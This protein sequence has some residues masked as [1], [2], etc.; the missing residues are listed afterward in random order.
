MHDARKLFVSPRS[1]SARIAAAL[2]PEAG[3]A[4]DAQFRRK[5]DLHVKPETGAD[6]DRERI[7]RAAIARDL[8]VL[9]GVDTASISR[10]PT[11][12]WKGEATAPL[13][14]ADLPAPVL[15]KLARS[16][17]VPT[18]PRWEVA[19]PGRWLLAAAAAGAAA[20]VSITLPGTS[21]AGVALCVALAVV[22][23]AIAAIGF[24][25]RQRRAHVIQGVRLTR[26]E[27]DLV[28]AARA[29]R[30]LRWN[31]LAEEGLT[32]LGT[33][34]MLYAHDLLEA[35]GRHQVW[36]D[37]LFVAAMG[38]AP[39]LDTDEEL[40]QIACSC[41]LLDRHTRQPLAVDASAAIEHDELEGRLR[42]RVLALRLYLDELDTAARVLQAHRADNPAADEQ[43]SEVFQAAAEN[44]FASATIEQMRHRISASAL[45]I[46]DIPTR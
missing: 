26:A 44:E 14:T 11:W 1:S 28:A 3:C 37:P 36:R 43:Q 40:F 31:P 9:A 13:R 30:T 34:I 21:R 42:E 2:T 29:R 23:F 10:G 20:A 12:A 27:R 15:D 16:A 4:Q 35:I 18:K 5:A 41:Q 7:V 39:R 19:H 22:T 45:A 8:A 24:G 32:S 25:S 6:S 46:R 33:G 17:R 38:P